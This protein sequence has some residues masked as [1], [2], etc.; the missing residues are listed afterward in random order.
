ML[1]TVWPLFSG[2]AALRERSDSFTLIFQ[3]LLISLLIS[4]SFDGGLFKIE[5]G[6]VFWLVLQATHS[7][8][9]GVNRNTL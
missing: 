2:G 9:A 8:A 3:A 7:D 5:V 4:L 1:A 6:P